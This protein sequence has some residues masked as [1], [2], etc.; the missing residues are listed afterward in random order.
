MRPALLLIDHGSRVP[1]ANLALPELGALV[2]A[3]LAERAAAERAT[4]E[5]PVAPM[6]VECA[7]MELA[8]PS[9]DDAVRSL[10]DAGADEIVAVPCMLTPG[11]HATEDIPRLVAEAAERH[12]LAH[13]VTPPLGVHRLLA[14]LVLVRASLV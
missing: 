8:A 9:I 1:E 2:R 6:A 4:A 3:A 11:R 5:T 10:K 12:G 7:H 14:E 13:R